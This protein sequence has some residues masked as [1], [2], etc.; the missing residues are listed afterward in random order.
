MAKGVPEETRDYVRAV[1]A[2]LLATRSQRELA[3][4]L[5]INQSRVS[6]AL[7]TGRLA[8]D[9]L[10]KAARLAGRS[11]DDVRQ[12]LRR[13]VGVAVKREQ[14][15][16]TSPGVRS[17]LTMAGVEELA[18]VAVERWSPR[19]DPKDA[20]VAVFAAQQWG[21]DATDKRTVLRAIEHIAL[22]HKTMHL[23]EEVAR[24]RWTLDALRRHVEPVLPDEL[25]AAEDDSDADSAVEI[26]T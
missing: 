24:L 9:T 16:P 12:H 18:R 2:D 10:W 7:N 4:E 25:D 5:E 11:E 15:S 6:S 22:A 13:T 3:A 20:L 17:S 26:L 19:T 14:K 1:F 23:A 21:Y 8:P